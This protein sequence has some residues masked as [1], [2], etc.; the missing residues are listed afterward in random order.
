MRLTR[1]LGLGVCVKAVDGVLPSMVR[2]IN[3]AL[4]GQVSSAGQSRGR[5]LALGPAVAGLAPGFGGVEAARWDLGRLLR[6]LG[7]G[8]RGAPGT[9]RRLL[10][11]AAP[12]AGSPPFRSILNLVEGGALTLTLHSEPLPPVSMRMA[13]W[14]VMWRHLAT[15]APLR[16]LVRPSFS[17]RYLWMGL[18]VSFR[19]VPASLPGTLAI[20]SVATQELVG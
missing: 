3:G 1:V 5:P 17:L 14:V 4:P 2:P 19:E 8:G 6:G 12:A 11:L 9:V 7:L 18:S 15:L 10:L 20:L 13:V 16:I